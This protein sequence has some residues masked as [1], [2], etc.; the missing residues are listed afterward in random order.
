M[1]YPI[2]TCGDSALTVKVGDGISPEVH[3]RVVSFCTALQRA[4][5]AGIRELVPTYDSVCVHYDPWILSEEQFR[6]LL[7]AMPVSAGAA[8]D[9]ATPRTVRIPVCY[10]GEY[11]PDLAA[12]AAHAGM[13]EQE[14]VE[15]HGSGRYLTYMLGFLPGF[16]YLGGMDE[17]IA[18]PRLK[19]PRANIPAGSV[20]IAG[21]Q[22]GIY[23]LSSPGGWQLIG[24]TPRKLFHF[25][26]E[27]AQFLL[28][29]G[30][31]VEFYPISPEEYV[32]MEEDA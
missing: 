31:L 27:T 22:T 8:Q 26:E 20:G 32:R 16:A 5:I 28:S 14:I 23:P 9:V 18:C 24:R 7:R 1:D 11:G 15:I 21:K 2:L 17:R 12:V 3:E 29:A 10:G 6:S 25:T 4:G 19:T 30:D 13:T